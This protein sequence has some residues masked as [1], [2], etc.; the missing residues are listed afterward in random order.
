MK[1]SQT[2]NSKR[3]KIANSANIYRATKR[4]S[5]HNPNKVGQGEL[6]YRWYKE[7]KEQT[8]RLMAEFP[9]WMRKYFLSQKLI[10]AV[11]KQNMK[12]QR[13]SAVC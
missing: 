10:D 1:E 3:I 4:C 13:R 9:L 12:R 8:R 2:W 5:I 6:Y 7:Y 11:A